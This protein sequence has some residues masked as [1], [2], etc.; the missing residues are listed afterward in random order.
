MITVASVSAGRGLNTIARHEAADGIL[1][2]HRPSSWMNEQPRSAITS[3][4]PSALAKAS[5]SVHS[6]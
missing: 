6:T 4:M 1:P 3:G 2:V 5:L